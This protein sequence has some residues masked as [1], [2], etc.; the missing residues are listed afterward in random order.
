MAINEW[1]KDHPRVLETVYRITSRLVHTSAPLLERIGYERAAKVFVP[2]EKISKGWIFGCK[3]CGQCILHSTG[4]TCPETCPKNL[5]NGPCGGV[6][7]DG[8]CEVIPSMPC[9]WVK[10]WERSRHMGRYGDEI[11]IVQPP[12]NRALA[13]TS[14]WL[15]DVRSIAK[16]TPAGW[17][18]NNDHPGDHP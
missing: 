10:A 1:L 16:Q 18:A 7:P 12:V 14:A 6:R 13:G 3:M 9:V 8:Y 15:N 4:M 2:L 11:L 17:R 5:R